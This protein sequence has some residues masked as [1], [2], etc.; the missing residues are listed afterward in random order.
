MARIWPRRA[1]RLIFSILSDGGSVHLSSSPSTTFGS[2]P[3][4]TIFPLD[5][6]RV[7]SGIPGADMRRDGGRLIRSSMLASAPAVPSPAGAANTFGLVRD[8][9]PL[10]FVGAS[11]FA[12][13]HEGVA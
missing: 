2:K 9:P 7:G 10:V 11:H 3:V 4:N 8:R 5:G 1:F 12:A 13:L 6:V